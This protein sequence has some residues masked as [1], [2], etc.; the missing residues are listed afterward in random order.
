MD[1]MQMRFN[2]NVEPLF[3]PG[4]FIALIGGDPDTHEFKQNDV[5]NFIR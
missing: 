1:R 4:V 3:G 2:T 5:Y